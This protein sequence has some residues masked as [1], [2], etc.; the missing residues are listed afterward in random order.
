MKAP[1]G[2]GCL[3]SLIRGL[4]IPIQ[5]HG[6]QMAL[7]SALTRTGPS[8]TGGL[9]HLTRGIFQAQTPS[10]SLPPAAHPLRPPTFFLSKGRARSRVKYNHPQ[11]GILTQIGL[12]S[13]SKVSPHRVLWA[14][15]P[16]WATT[17]Q[18]L[19]QR[20]AYVPGQPW[21]HRVFPG[22]KGGRHVN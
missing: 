6:G 2:S 13:D 8:K 5:V 10:P 18:N 9:P 16:S 22:K 11:P 20:R 1:G 14:E 17:S 15:T 7:A 12:S 19:S 3:L 4:P 21:H